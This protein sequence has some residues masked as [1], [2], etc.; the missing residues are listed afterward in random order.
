MFCCASLEIMECPALPLAVSSVAR[1][2]FFLQ[3][4]FL[5][6]S[7]GG[8]N[9]YSQND[10]RDEIKVWLETRAWNIHSNL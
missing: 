4:P 10:Y 8:E 5:H 1:H 7:N 3:S 2:V 6:L 9:N